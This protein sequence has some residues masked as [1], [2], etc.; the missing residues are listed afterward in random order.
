LIVVAYATGL[1]HS[2]NERG[3]T[4][5]APAYQEGDRPACTS[6]RGR[7]GIPEGRA[8]RLVLDGMGQGP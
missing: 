4:I 7:P 1:A 6:S 5:T 2:G 3:K 8:L